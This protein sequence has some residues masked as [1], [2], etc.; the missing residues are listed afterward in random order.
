MDWIFFYVRYNG[1]VLKPDIFTAVHPDIGRK[2]ILEKLKI[3]F[4]DHLV[5]NTTRQFVW[6]N[7]FKIDH[8]KYNSS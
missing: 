1:E 5:Y 3:E 7:L 8:Q 2:C 4:D 6:Y